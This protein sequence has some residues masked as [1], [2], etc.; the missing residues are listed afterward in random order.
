MAFVAIGCSARHVG[1]VRN[2]DTECSAPET[3]I[4][5]E[6]QRAC[7]RL[8]TI[9]VLRAAPMISVTSADL[10]T[11]APILIAPPIRMDPAGMTPATTILL[12]RAAAIPIRPAAITAPNLITA[13]PMAVIHMASQ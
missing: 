13:R 3:K 5:N 12:M 4:C 7:V 11:G 1:A 2:V 9:P 8:R 6:S 10:M